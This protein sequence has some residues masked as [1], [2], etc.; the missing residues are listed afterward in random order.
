MLALR[1]GYSERRGEHRGETV[2]DVA[3][4]VCSEG[5]LFI[6]WQSEVFVIQL[7]M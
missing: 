5:G 4:A 1:S 6:V 7:D 3:T 2:D